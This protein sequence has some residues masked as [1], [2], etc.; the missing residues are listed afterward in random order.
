MPLCL[1]E[2][3][4]AAWDRECPPW[5]SLLVKAAKVYKSQGEWACGFFCRRIC[6]HSLWPGFS[7]LIHAC[8]L[9]ACLPACLFVIL[10]FVYPFFV[11]L[12]WFVL[13]CSDLSLVLCFVLTFLFCVVVLSCSGYFL[14]FFVRV[15]CA[16]SFMLL[17]F[18]LFFAVVLYVP[19]LLLFLWYFSFLFVFAFVFPWFLSFMHVLRNIGPGGPKQCGGSIKGWCL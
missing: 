3:N 2:S 14:L 18:Q 19:L 5:P 1:R 17:F 10:C 9:L 16:C 11:Y 7:I 12:F 6:S 13:P 15:L 4:F 8:C